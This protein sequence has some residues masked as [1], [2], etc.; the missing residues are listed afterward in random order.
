MIFLEELIAKKGQS[1]EKIVCHAHQVFSAQGVQND[2]FQEVVEACG[3]PEQLTLL[4]REFYRFSKQDPQSRSAYQMF[5]KEVDDS[6]FALSEWIESFAEVFSWLEKENKTNDL[7][8][9][10]KYLSCCTQVPENQMFQHT[11][12]EITRKML[13]DYG[14][15]M[16]EDQDEPTN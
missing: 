16:A 13:E 3:T 9:V 15:E 7:F 10:L 12:I 5:I 1:W 8:N 6:D 2:A 4:S 14:M 11:L